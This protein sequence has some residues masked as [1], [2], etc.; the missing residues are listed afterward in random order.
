VSVEWYHRDLGLR[1]NKLAE[2]ILLRVIE[3]QQIQAAELKSIKR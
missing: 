1:G 2:K 3:L